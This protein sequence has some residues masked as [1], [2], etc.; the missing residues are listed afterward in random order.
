MFPEC[1]LNDHFLFR[2]EDEP[3]YLAL[4]TAAAALQLNSAGKYSCGREGGDLKTTPWGGSI[5]SKP[6]GWA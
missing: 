3:E 2:W 4:A 1:S 6:D 5:F